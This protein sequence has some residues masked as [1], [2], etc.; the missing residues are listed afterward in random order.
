MLTSRTVTTSRPSIITAKPRRPL[1]AVTTA[2]AETETGPPVSYS[3]SV[4]IER[5]YRSVS[6]SK[7]ESIV[8]LPVATVSRSATSEA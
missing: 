6:W 8:S 2:E 7:S 4:C 3:I 5:S 1:R